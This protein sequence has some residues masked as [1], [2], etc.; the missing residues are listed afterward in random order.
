MGPPPWAA[1]SP[2]MRGDATSRGCLPL[3]C[4]IPTRYET[5]GSGGSCHASSR[6]R[7]WQCSPLIQCRSSSITRW[8]SY[9][10]AVTSPSF[11]RAGTLSPGQA[12]QWWGVSAT[13]GQVRD[14]ADQLHSLHH[15]RR[16]KELNVDNLKSDGPFKRTMCPSGWESTSQPIRRPPQSRRRSDTPRRR[17]SAAVGSFGVG[18]QLALGG[19]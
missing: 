14:A 7:A 13:R 1:P 11:R 9:S 18:G 10:S 17:S 15:R 16:H 12:R 3:S 4:R 6:S 19:G 5:A 8:P 2:V